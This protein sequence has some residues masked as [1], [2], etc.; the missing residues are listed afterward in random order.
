MFGGGVPVL[1][2]IDR[3]GLHPIM[4]TDGPHGLRKQAYRPGPCRHRRE[5]PRRLLPDR[6]RPGLFL[7]PAL[8]RE[9]GK[10]IA[11]ECRQ[12]EVAVLLGPGVNMKRS[13]LCG[14]NFE[15]F[16]EDPFLAG[17]CAAA[18][19]DGVQSQGVGVCLSTTPPTT[20]KKAA[21]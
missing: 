15:Y 11:E 9:V 12:E 6:L 19:I 20:R 4:V 3:L 10:A 5:R 1:K 7:G 21:W 17:E 18:F 13:P 16:S 2:G 8:L 14:R